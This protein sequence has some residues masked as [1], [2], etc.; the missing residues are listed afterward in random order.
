VSSWVP[1]SENPGIEEEEQRVKVP[2]CPL[3]LSTLCSLLDSW[4]LESPH[5]SLVKRVKK[6]RILYLFSMLF[7]NGKG[8]EGTHLMI[9]RHLQKN[10]KDV[11]GPLKTIPVTRIPENGIVLSEF[12]ATVFSSF[13]WCRGT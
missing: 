7:T 10:E 6:I 3:E 1:D 5:P 12:P 4:F 9:P 11:P 2:T 8:E 13:E